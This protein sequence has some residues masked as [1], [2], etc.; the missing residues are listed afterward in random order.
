MSSMAA[1]I[2]NRMN[3]DA[4][5]VP[6]NVG[7]GTPPAAEPSTPDSGVQAPAGQT[8]QTGQV[9]D[10]IPYSR[11]KE[12]N[13]RLSSLRG[14][15]TLAS[16]GYDPDSLGR[17]AAF[18]AQYQQDAYGTLATMAENL[19]LPDE[20][21]N[22]IRNAGSDGSSQTAEATPTGEQAGSELPP[23]VQEA[24]QYVNELRA[25]DE[26]SS[27]DA[28]LDRVLAAWD[29]MDSKSSIDET[30][31]RIKLM[32]IQQVAGSG[33]FATVEDLAQAARTSIME[34]R[35]TVLGGAVRRTGHGVLPPALP[36][37]PPSPSEPVKFDSLKSASKAAAAAIERGELPGL[38]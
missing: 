2:M 11:F 31:M 10:T 9:P 16:Y 38:V 5:G 22:A 19:E 3:E 8:G 29:D 15:E 32:A 13:D 35:D 34:Y 18:E 6:G 23:E 36:G 14:Y 20:V 21:I 17:L 1:E 7:E 30:P 27:R 26:A 12:V 37:S 28:Q 25:R 24:L 4:G 33:Q